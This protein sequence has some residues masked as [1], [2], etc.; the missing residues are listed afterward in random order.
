MM[1]Y[2][3]MGSEVDSG[4]P[5]IW[6]ARGMAASRREVLPGISVPIVAVSSMYTSRLPYSSARIFYH[7]LLC[8]GKWDVC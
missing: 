7:S 6:R 2:R 8:R 1:G 3:G 4:L 5:K